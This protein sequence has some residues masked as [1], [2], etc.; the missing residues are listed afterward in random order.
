MRPAFKSVIIHRPAGRLEFWITLAALIFNAC[1]VTPT[2]GAPAQAGLTQR[3]SLSALGVSS[4]DHPI[5]MIRAVLERPIKNIIK[6]GVTP[7]EIPEIE[8]ETAVR[9]FMKSHENREA[10]V[11]WYGVGFLRW[12]VIEEAKKE[13]FSTSDGDDRISD[14]LRL[15]LRLALEYYRESPKDYASDQQTFLSEAGIKQL[16]QNVLAW[17]DAVSNGFVPKAKFANAHKTARQSLE[18][19]LLEVVQLLTSEAIAKENLPIIAPQVASP[20]VD[21]NTNRPASEFTKVPAAG[22]AAAVAE[23]TFDDLSRALRLYDGVGGGAVDHDAARALL[24]KANQDDPLV[25]MWLARSHHA[26]RMKFSLNVVEGNRLANEALPQIRLLADGGQAEAQFLLGSALTEGIG[27][28]RDQVQAVK[29]LTLAAAQN[30]PAARNSLAHAYW[31]GGGVEK[32]IARALELNL[33]AAQ[34]GQVFAVM[35]CGLILLAGDGV[36]KNADEGV[37]WLKAAAERGLGPAQDHLGT[38]LVSGESV[39]QDVAAGVAWWRRAAEQGMAEA[40][41]RLYDHLVVQPRAT[42]RAE[43]QGWLKKAADAGRPSAM[44]KQ[45]VEQMR[46]SNDREALALFIKSGNKGYVPAMIEAGRMIRD[47]RGTARSDTSALKWFQIALKME[48]NNSSALW[49]VA[50]M[51]RA[52]QG[53]ARDEAEAW[54]LS[55]RAAELGHEP[56]IRY[57][58]V[59]HALGRHIP[60]NKT[61]AFEWFKRL[62]SPRWNAADEIH[63][64][65]WKL[66]MGFKPEE[67]PEDKVKAAVWYRHAADLGNVRAMVGLAELAEHEAKYGKSDQERHAARAV[68]WYRRAAESGDAKAMLMLGLKLLTGAGVKQDGPQA[69]DWFRKAIDKSNDADA[70]SRLTAKYARQA[71][72][73]FYASSIGSPRDNAQALEWFKRAAGSDA[74]L[75]S[76]LEEVASAFRFGNDAPKDEQAYVYWLQEAATRGHPEAM[77]DLSQELE[78]GK[79]LARQT[80]QAASWLRKSAEAGHVAAM[81]EWGER[82]SAGKGVAVDPSAAVS[83]FRRALEEVARQEKSGNWTFGLGIKVHQAQ[84]NMGYAH[85]LGRGAPQDEAEATVW[86][87]RASPEANEPAESYRWLGQKLQDGDG[88]PADPVAAVTWFKKAAELGHLIAVLDVALALDELPEDK[89]PAAE[90]IAWYERAA[91]QEGEVGGI[92]KYRLGGIYFKGEGVNQNLATALRWFKAAAEAGQVQAMS[93]YGRMLRRG[94]GAPANPTEGERWIAE[95]RAKGYVENPKDLADNDDFARSKAPKTGTEVERGRQDGTA[96][97]SAP[98]LAAADARTRAQT[99]AQGAAVIGIAVLKGQTLLSVDSPVTGEEMGQTLISELKAA[100]SRGAATDSPVRAVA[101]T[102]PGVESNS[103]DVYYFVGERTFGPY[104]FS[105]ARSKVDEIA[106]TFQR[107]RT[108][109]GNEGRRGPLSP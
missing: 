79:L 99:A 4:N 14:A 40:Q 92:A 49:Q 74:R 65:A 11:F 87:R 3:Y 57:V 24:L 7:G 91:R 5:T 33:Q 16:A 66:N 32:N 17:D 20:S 82:L 27:V 90:V 25:K 53:V 22:I 97:S 93:V 104:R 23:L 75:A 26:G 83:W 1:C 68:E 98:A 46:R 94:L 9:A 41:E 21:S 39:P 29:W 103:A 89:R 109:T 64:F 52:G 15:L 100:S 45:A 43:A 47:G 28:R 35:A 42:E 108:P 56:A 86:F 96:A 60:E 76:T 58:A 67:I 72:G 18:E 62:K 44:F 85:A 30:H 48:T 31:T 10:V 36:P 81:F 13:G 105:V 8:V 37:R 51:T 34:Q 2:D 102:D 78:T 77:F 55:L 95:A 80:N 54:R 63:D 107:S 88:F 84:K 6:P 70:I 59:A 38:L 19:Q 69:A 61:A 106:N 50:E 12:G 73:I 101:Y 71:L